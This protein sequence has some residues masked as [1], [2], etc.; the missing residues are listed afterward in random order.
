LTVLAGVLSADLKLSSNAASANNFLVSLN[1]ES[2]GVHGLRAQVPFSSV[3]ALFSATS[4][5]NYNNSTGA[6]TITLADAT[7][8]GYL[9]S[10]D[11]NTF[12]NK[13]SAL[14]FGNLTDA[15]TDG[16]VITGGTGAVIGTGTSI[17]QH[18]ADSTHNG[19]LSSTD[20]STF[21]NKQPAGS[22]ITALTG[23]VTA[24][25]PGS[26]AATIANNAVTNAKLA[27]MPTL[28]IKG[29]N[30]GGTA[31]ALDLTVAQVNAILPVFTNTLNGLAPLSGGGTSNFLRAD[32]TWAAPSG[33]G[34]NTALSNLASVAIN[35]SLLP[36]AS[37][38]I[39][40]GSATFAWN[41]AYLTGFIKDG[42]TG[43]NVL[44]ISNRRVMD[45][46]GNVMLSWLNTA[47][48]INAETHKITNVVDP[49]SA[50]DAATK[51]YVDTTRL[52]NTLTSAHLF[53]G[54]GSNVATD[55]AVSGDLTLANTGA[56]TFNTVNGNVGTFGTASSVGTFTVNAKGLITA[57]SN[58]SI[59]ITESQVTN[60]TTDLAAKLSNTLTDSHI[61]VGNGSNVATDVALSGDATL[62]NT[63]ALTLATVNSNVGSFGSSTAIPSFTVN[64]KGLITAA[65]T[66]AVIAP[67]GTLTGTTLASNVVSSSLTSLGT[68]STGVWN[69]TAIGPTFGGTGQTTYATGDILY[70]S[71]SNT[72]SKLAIGSTDQT[73]KVSGGVPVWG[74]LA[75]AGGGTGATTKAAA[76][77]ALS[78]MTTGGDLIYGGASGT[79]TRLANGTSGQFLKSN[80]GTSAPSWATVTATYTAPTIQ[81]FSSGSGTYTTPAN[82][83][84]LRVR[85]VGGGGGGGGS[86]NA[87]GSAGTAGG[88]GGNSTFGSSFLTANGGNGGGV[89]GSSTQGG[90]GGSATGGDSNMAGGAGG[91]SLALSTVQI[92]GEGASN[93]WG[94]GGGQITTT[95]T[96]VAGN[97]GAANGTGG[98]GSGGIFS[99]GAGGG[100]G[101]FV[102][103]IVTSPSATYAYAIGA[104]GSAGSA[105]TSGQAG[106]AGKIGYLI[107]EE[108]YQ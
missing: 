82:V 98:S 13:Q 55:V 43:N 9:S 100:S 71:A 14:T 81:S 26:V 38:T 49:G 101:G 106:G 1:I 63:G 42:S 7:H 97:A 8:D 103:K 44:D 50:Q 45:T 95:G 65:S 30:T 32:G 108:Y 41:N 107:V 4:P 22:Y 99:S 52:S 25:G 16:I 5:L 33:S 93:Y 3:R 60:L 80:G 105:G 84:Y 91:S 24:T 34:A 2:T 64:A 88:N 46:A 29:N 62:A 83:L 94:A 68:I 21:N 73:L 69:G 20:W 53:V 18:V 57:A 92:G 54:N 61:F 31:N 6:F 40:L 17:S 86:Q 15:G 89:S 87:A 67:A 72:L 77:D 51:N 70:A 11:W 27:Q 12:N 66:N 74:T 59:Q 96:S 104:A 47:T 23:D 48:G 10:T 19:Y 35:T 39:D 85:L 58:T 78:P 37:G 36:G 56:F 79:G 90:T 75:I 76:F 28:T 102:E